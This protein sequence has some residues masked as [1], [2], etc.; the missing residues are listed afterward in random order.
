MGAGGRQQA[1]G[2]TPHSCKQEETERRIERQKL[3]FHLSSQSHISGL[4]GHVRKTA[5]DTVPKPMA[6][7]RG[8]NV[9]INKMCYCSF[10]AENNDGLEDWPLG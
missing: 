9:P 5:G 7:L 10:I 6:S 1:P 4:V 8:Q 3:V 2:S